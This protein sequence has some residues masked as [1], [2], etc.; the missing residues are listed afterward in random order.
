MANAA[1]VFTQ[2]TPSA[3]WTITHGLNTDRPVVNVYIDDKMMLPKEIRVVTTND[4]QITFTT[5][6]AGVAVIS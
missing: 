5:A 6:Q 3:S 1:V 4:V 2:S